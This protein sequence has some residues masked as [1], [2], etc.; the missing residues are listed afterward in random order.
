MRPFFARSR[1]L[2]RSTI[3]F[4]QEPINGILRHIVIGVVDVSVKPTGGPTQQDRRF[5]WALAI[6]PPQQDGETS[7]RPFRDKQPRDQ[8]A[9]GGEGRRGCLVA[10]HSDH[11]TWYAL[12]RFG[13]R[14]LRIQ[15]GRAARKRGVISDQASPD[16]QTWASPGKSPRAA[17]ASTVRFLRAGTDIA[18]QTSRARLQHHANISAWAGGSGQS[19]T[20]A[21]GGRSRRA[22]HA[23]GKICR[24]LCRG[25]TIE[26]D[27][28]PRNTRCG[29]SY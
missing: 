22:N 2:V 4:F 21:L 5:A 18:S 11:A 19:S 9:T 15:K 28:P 6:C 3:G 17:N 10:S 16:W 24:S 29:V 12:N 8:R 20:K 23:R 13:T 27:C 1:Y 7:A 26:E 25:R 14:C